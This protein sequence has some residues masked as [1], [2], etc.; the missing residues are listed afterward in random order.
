MPLSIIICIFLI[1]VAMLFH[2][3]LVE[4]VDSHTKELYSN[5]YY[6]QMEIVRNYEKI[7]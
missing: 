6:I 4:Q 1:Y 7:F 3:Q 2:G 5:A